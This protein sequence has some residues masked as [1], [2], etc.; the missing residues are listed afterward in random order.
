VAPDQVT[1]IGKSE[2]KFILNEPA[3]HAINIAVF[4]NITFPTAGVY[5]VEVLVDSVM[6]IRYPL[7]VVIVQPPGANPQ[8]PPPKAGT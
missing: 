2:T 4:A 7:P 3:A 8:P 1:E 5:Y 6:K